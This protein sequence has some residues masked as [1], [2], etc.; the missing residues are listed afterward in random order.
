MVNIRT[1]RP[2]YWAVYRDLRLR[3]L[4]DSP[5]AFGSTFEEEHQRPNDAWVAR[6]AGP[7]A[8]N[9]QQSWPFA[10]EVD[11]IP[12]GLAWVKLDVLATKTAHLYHVWVAPQAR[13]RGVG[14]GLLNAAIEWTR[15]H[16]ATTLHLE[17]T[18]SSTAARLY[19]RSGF[20]N[21]GSPVPMVGRDTFEQAMVLTLMA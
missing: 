2:D 5:A 10:A 21:I 11:G 16:G 8:D 6:L 4:S 13:G 1:L 18:S 3:A 12:V 17:V 20:V 19:R 14:A 7:A 9:H 15:E